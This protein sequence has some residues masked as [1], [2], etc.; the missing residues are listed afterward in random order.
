[1]KLSRKIVSR[2]LGTNY[3]Y[4]KRKANVSKRQ[5][6]KRKKALIEEC[7]AAVSFLT[8]HKCV[9]EI[10]VKDIESQ[11][12]QTLTL[13]KNQSLHAEKTVVEESEINKWLYVKD[14][15]CIS[16]ETSRAYPT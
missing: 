5:Q 15:H 6:E 11:E 12:V 13:S 14:K 16:N 10:K 8:P 4:A 1:M 3:V 9:V 7:R 2:T